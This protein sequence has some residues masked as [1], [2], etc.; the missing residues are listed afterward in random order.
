MGLVSVTVVP[1]AST[2]IPI[3]IQGGSGRTLERPGPV[4][5]TGHFIEL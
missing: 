2:D 5:C 4:F 1:R 3:E